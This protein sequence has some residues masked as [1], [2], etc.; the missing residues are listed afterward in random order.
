MTRGSHEERERIHPEV[1]QYLDP[2]GEKAD[3][4]ETS[5]REEEP[6]R[7]VCVATAMHLSKTG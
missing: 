1:P 6:G 3:R 2:T 7:D 4:K 5:E